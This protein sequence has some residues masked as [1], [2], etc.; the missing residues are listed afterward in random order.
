VRTEVNGC[1]AVFR[2]PFK[3]DAEVRVAAGAEDQARHAP[4]VSRAREPVGTRFRKGGVKAFRKNGLRAWGPSSDRLKVGL[5]SGGE[6]P[7]ESTGSAVVKVFRQSAPTDGL[8][9]E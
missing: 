8:L 4:I 1:A 9:G 7:C 6:A 2:F 3:E 5:V